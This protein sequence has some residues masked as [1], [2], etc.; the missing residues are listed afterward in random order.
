MS[1]SVF[2]ALGEVGDLVAAAPRLLLALNHDGVLVPLADQPMTETVRASLQSLS[3]SDRLSL[4]VLSRRER[5]DLQ[6]RVGI[7]GIYYAG[8]HGLEI[9]GPGWMFIEPTA[10][11]LAPALK[12]VQ[13]ELQER[14]QNI[15]AVR[16]DDKGFALAVRLDL[17]PVDDREEV[18]RI[19]HAALAKASHP[20][21]LVAGDK[22]YEV[23]PRV[24][25]NEATAIGHIK[26]H[27]G[28]PDALTIYV[29]HEGN[30]EGFAEL[31]DAITVRVADSPTTAAR[32]TVDSADGVPPFLQW[33]ER[34]LLPAERGRRATKDSLENSFF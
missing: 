30:E 21:H 1:R 17:V 29:G 27:L 12:E 23:R 4:A 5:A 20:F 15:P 10:A 16:I 13:N 24:Y 14:L 33:L 11:A 34:Q 31:A 9:S 18:K 7:P 25:W 22:V 32:F 26:K 6:E 8:N 3:S 19:I 2:N 28:E